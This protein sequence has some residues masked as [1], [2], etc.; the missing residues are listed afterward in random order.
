[1]ELRKIVQIDE[2]LCDG[3]GECVPSCAEGALQIVDGKAKLVS[4]VFCDGLGACLGDCPQGAITIEEREAAG[5]DEE[6]VEDHLARIDAKEPQKQPTPPV[7]QDLPCGCPGSA[8]KSFS[9]KTP[10]AVVKTQPATAGT[11]Q[12]SALTHWPV[13][14]MLIPPGAPFLRNADLLICADCVP[15]TVP[16]FHSRYLEDRTVLVGCP[17]LDDIELYR[18]K[19]G[20]IFAASNP[21][22]IT[23]L[24]MEVPCCSGIAHAVIEA[25]DEAASHLPVE[26]HTI[27]I[28]GGSQIEV[29]PGKAKAAQGSM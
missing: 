1:M 11:S 18:H 16:D 15:F 13:Q 12:P 8:V 10:K 27:G 5:F 7:H 24:K 19:L 17:K 23:V 4:D 26:V 2:E 14:L 29:S 9:P 22:S 28:R 6:A 20:E 21:S 3:C 25:R